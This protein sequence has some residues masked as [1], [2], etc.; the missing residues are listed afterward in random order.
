[1]SG[2]RIGWFL[3][4]IPFMAASMALPGAHAAQAAAMKTYTNNKA[5]YRISYPADWTVVTGQ[6]LDLMLRTT[7]RNAFITANAS[8]ASGSPA[9]INAAQKNVF[10]QLGTLQGKVIVRNKKVG[11]LAIETAE[12]VVK[13]NGKRIDVYLVDVSRHG[14]IYDFNAG[15]VLGTPHTSAELAAISASYASIQIR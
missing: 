5:G 8:R 6:G 3:A 4:L 1:M 14:Y 13:S 9:Q 2:R 15:V 10:K 12:A 7:D 11:V